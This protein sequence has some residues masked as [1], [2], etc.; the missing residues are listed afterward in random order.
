TYV[1]ADSTA[2][3]GRRTF[4]VIRVPQYDDLTLTGT[5]TA[6]NWNG[7]SG[8]VI[9]LDVAST[10]DLGGQLIDA[11]GAGFRGAHGRAR[12]TGDANLRYVRSDDLVHA[13]K[14]EGIAGTPRYVSNKRDF[15]GNGAGGSTDL[16]GAWPGYQDGTTTSGNF[17]RGAPGNAGGG[18]NF[19]NG[20]SDNGGGGGGGNGGAGGRGGAG[21][22]SGGYG[23]GTG[24]D[25]NPINATFSNHPEKKWAF[26]GAAFAGASLSRLV[27]GGGG[28]AG[29]N[30]GNSTSPDF[31]AG[32]AG[33]GIV[34]VRARRI[35]GAGTIRVRGARATD[36]PRNDGGGGG[37]AG[38]SVALLAAELA[39]GA[40]V[41][42]DARGGRGGNA[43][44]DGGAI[45]RNAHGPGGGGAGG[46]V[47]R[48]ITATVNVAGGG[49]GL[50]ENSDNGPDGQN[51][52]ARPGAAGSD[53]LLGL[54]SDPVPN[55]GFRC[56]DY[57]D[58]DSSYGSARHQ[59]AADPSDLRI[60]AVSPDGDSLPES[61]LSSAAATVDNVTD[62]DDEEGVSLPSSSTS[63]GIY[64]ASVATENGTG[65]TA[66]LCGW[67]DFDQDGAFDSDERSCANVGS[68]ALTTALSF[69]V[70]VAD[71][72]NSGTFSARFRLG[73]AANATLVET[74][75]GLAGIGEVEDYTVSITTLPVTLASVH[76]R[77][78]GD[79]LQIR[80][81]TET[82]TANAGF[83]VHGRVTGKERWQVLT[84]ELVPSH[85]IDSHEPLAYEVTIPNAA[86][87]DEIAIEDWDTRGQPTWNGP[88]LVGRLHGLD[89]VAASTPIDWRAIR[90]EN[91]RVR[92]VRPLA[93]STSDPDV[94]LWVESPGIQRLSV[95]SLPTSFLGVAISTV[96][97]TDEGQRVP[98]H[99]I[100]SGEDGFLDATDAI[101]FVGTVNETLY[102][103]RNA[104]RLF[105]DP[106]TAAVRTAANRRLG[107][108]GAITDVVEGL[109]ASDQAGSYSFT[110]PGDDPFYDE[111]LF[112]RDGRPDVIER[113]FDLPGYAGTGPVSLELVLW[114]VTDFPGIEPDHH[115]QIEV[116]GVPV[117][118]LRFDGAREV[119]VDVVLEGEMLERQNTLR[120]LAPG[121]TGFAYDITALDRFSV[122]YDRLSV[123]EAGAWQGEIVHD[124]KVS[125][126]GFQ[127]AS[128]AWND[129]KR[130]EGDTALIVKGA[131]T[132]TAAEEAR[133]TAPG[134]VPDPVL[135]VD[136]ADIEADYL[137]VTHPQFAGSVA[138]ADL[139]AL[140]E[141]RGY[142]T[143]VV[144]TD[145][146]YASY[147]DHETSPV[148]IAAFVADVRPAYLLLLGGDSYDYKDAL[149]LGSE[150]FVPT[151]YVA[152][153]QLVTYAPS[154]IPFGDFNGDGLPQAAVG[155]LPV[156][157]VSEL[158]LLVA[159]LYAYAPPQRLVLAAGPSDSGRRFAEISDGYAAR[160]DGLLTPERFHA[161]DLGVASASAG[162][163]Q[164]LVQPGAVVSFVGHSSFRIWGLNPASGIML[165]ADDARALGNAWP[166][167]V[168]QWGCWNTY[169]VNPRQDTMANG[170]LLQQSGAAA[171]LGA[172]ALT[173]LGLLQEFGEVFFRQFGRQ[174]TLGDALR[175]TQRQ[176][177][178]ENMA[179]ARIMTLLGDPATPLR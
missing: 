144:R 57:G 58:A 23:P 79:D 54:A 52:G 17:A 5:V 87:F 174:P 24:T 85:R 38:G 7:D 111:W 152:T 135:P 46:V 159:K 75:T 6:A 62:V 77:G 45:N 131:G 132:W 78:H 29:D 110:A 112:A 1:R 147:S 8:G 121:D 101:E 151:F 114:G 18:G 125:I 16:G 123:A 63:D 27:F 168:T 134:V 3:T 40:S 160:L 93:K 109:A 104:Y 80:W 148:A 133:L 34:L 31:S 138:L 92:S 67:V 146:I 61:A 95:A 2:T 42:I 32:A 30:N 28:G 81:T 69:T 113:S 65:A 49:N 167:L 99:I 130:R 39:G 44:F 177:A 55:A 129:R 105:V 165:Q 149:G 68:G 140:Q 142:R 82:E 19:W 74:P 98:R 96:A 166:H 139:V 22:R 153:D 179:G 43:H 107:S 119:V 41:T 48:S 70:P 102:S 11:D 150:S 53:T 26:G 94:L 73:T 90:R 157:T 154:D 64:T 12:S 106:S 169:F 118:E 72:S 88:Y 170:F 178:P 89:A 108:R 59:L 71:R 161:D 4:Q 14:G 36:N 47:L 84:D 120:L 162:L 83:M 50:T 143:A 9:V 13:V 33:G 103:A 122:S 115:V 126:T 117:R 141:A 100:D 128:V 51:H 156:R 10:L 35:E 15:A 171:V 172:S 124:D 127:G 20:S 86:G 176:Y 97:I 37:G 163:F 21:W 116:N 76:A 137:I 25:G 136:G 60:G 164:A 175:R 173:D 91:T 66:R 145:A 56:I 155:R 158:E